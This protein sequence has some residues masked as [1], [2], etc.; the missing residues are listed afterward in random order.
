MKARQVCSDD[1]LAIETLHGKARRA[2]PQMW[3][4]EEYLAR[5]TFVIAEHNGAVMGVLFAWPD[6][7]PVA[8]ARVAALDNK[9]DVNAWLDSLLPS[10]LDGLRR[11][12]S[13]ALAWMDYA[14]W[15]GIHLQARGFKP[16]TDVVTYSKFD[17]SL[18]SVD[19]TGI[20]LC[21]ASDEDISTVVAIDRAAFAPH[22]W[23]SEDTVRRRATA[24]AHFYVARAGGEVVGY[25]EG[26]LRLPVAHLNRIAVLPSHQGRG[27]GASLLRGAIR[28]FW[29][30]KA[31]WVT[32]NTQS[33]NRLSQRLYRR[34]GFEATGDSTTVWE[35]KL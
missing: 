31:E 11:F 2:L 30:Q 27:I 32:L 16:L 4:W 29:Q 24:S 6:E 22:W 20:H 21:P 15:A 1:W 7:S 9:L 19:V 10:V 23:Q 17:Q 3:P 34:F 8:W 5:D 25:A 12:G 33:H 14:G 28:D 26:E 35:L 13:Q 18:P